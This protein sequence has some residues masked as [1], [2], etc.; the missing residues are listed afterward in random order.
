VVQVY[1]FNPKSKFIYT[2]YIVI[3]RGLYI[4]SSEVGSYTSTKS[5]MRLTKSMALKFLVFY[6]WKAEDYDTV[7]AKSK[8]VEEERKKNPEKFAKNLFPGHIL[9]GDLPIL[10]KDM[11]AFGIAEVDNPQPLI[12][13]IARWIP[14]VTV[15]L[16]RI[17]DAAKIVE[18][19][20]KL[21]K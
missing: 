8:Q 15:K 4:E 6:E 14:E 19:Y 12:N 17:E 21:K 3:L 5:K 18:A 11:R 16:V 9:A 10:T 20:E 7:I 2:V 1:I 13:G